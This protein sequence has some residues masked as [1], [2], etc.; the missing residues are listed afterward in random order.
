MDARVGIMKG[1]HDWI[2]ENSWETSQIVMVL[3]LERIGM[4]VNAIM[5][6][7]SDPESKEVNQSQMKKLRAKRH[8]RQREAREER[9]ALAAFGD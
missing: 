5:R 2:Y 6:T 4:M 9:E 3:I 7:T 8:Q 1:L